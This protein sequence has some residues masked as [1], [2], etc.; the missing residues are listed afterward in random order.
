MRVAFLDRDGT[1]IFEP[2]DGLVR[3]SEFRILPGVP[4]AL[5]ELKE[6][7]YALVM[8]T[9]QDFTRP[10]DPQE[11]FET[12]QRMLLAVLAE[13]GIAF[14]AIFLCPHP[15]DAGCPCRKPKTGM[16]D[17]F[18]RENDID[19]SASF[20]VG[21]RPENDGGLA[22]NIG[23]RYVRVGPNGAF[24]RAAEILAA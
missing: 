8:V 23:V 13:E 22:A 12:T 7:G 10:E 16:V 19:K 3:P 21:D 2:A 4:E 5:L 15:K 11:C 24:P 17:A 6:A 14:D 20:V 18:L 9:N 1:L